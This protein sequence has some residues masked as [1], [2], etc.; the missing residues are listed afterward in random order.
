MWQCTDS[1]SVPG[2][3]GNVDVNV[4]YSYFN[5]T[6]FTDIRLNGWYYEAVKYVY[7]NKIFYGTTA[8]TFEPGKNL[9]RGM[10]VTVL[11]RMEGEPSS[12]KAGFTDTKETSYYY[13]AVNWAASAG[14][15][16]GYSE[17]SFGPND[18]ITRQQL[19]VILRNYAS[20]K[21]YDVS[22]KK[23]ITSFEDFEQVSSYAVDAVSWA[24]GKGI[25]NGKSNGT[26]IDP[27]GNATRAEA[28]A[29]LTNYCMNILKK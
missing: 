22:T 13:N 15:V 25:I 27:K 2:I 7:Q 11:W 6:P 20:Y 29:M 26:Q 28:A 14:V 3:E 23:D 24:V 1:A 12:E 8:T 16:H 4:D 9:T 19:A 17:T 18:N 5:A 21:G 10:L